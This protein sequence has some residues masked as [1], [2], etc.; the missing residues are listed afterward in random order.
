MDAGH[1]GVVWTDEARDD[2]DAAVS[3]IA[4]DS[5]SAALLVLDRILAASRSLDVFAERGRVVPEWGETSVREVLV[6]PFRL[7]Y[8]VEERRVLVLTVIHQR[9]DFKR[10]ID[11]VQRRAD[12]H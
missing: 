7:V 2:L 6:D 9:R 5:V 10:W 1:R 12:P 3:F 11:D 8:L 4:E